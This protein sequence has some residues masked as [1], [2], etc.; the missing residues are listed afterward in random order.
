MQRFRCF[1]LIVVLLGCLNC[2][3]AQTLLPKVA[4]T[5]PIGADTDIW[6]WT[7]DGDHHKPIVKLQNSVSMGTGVIISI[8][9]KNPNNKKTEWV[10]GICLT[11]Y[12]VVY[13]W[14]P[15]LTEEELK[16][17]PE[18][19]YTKDR[20]IA[21]ENNWQLNRYKILDTDRE[22]DLAL[23][24]VWVP[25]CIVPA[26]VGTTPIKAGDSLEITGLGGGSPLAR[27]RHYS[28]AAHRF[29][30]E[31][32][33]HS[34]VV[35]MLGDS[36]GPVFNSKQEVVGIN[37]CIWFTWTPHE[38]RDHHGHM[39]DIGWPLKMAGVKPIN[40]LIEKNK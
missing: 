37:N 3:E 40:D 18:K 33:I 7:P 34:D 24:Q 35:A 15:G 13:E 25:D 23:L 30:D 10:Q 1:V 6:K 17:F 19:P 31:W 27:L 9:D 12:H 36:G 8:D 20:S 29:T 4:E 16:Q 38:I 11:A 22:N 39:A 21:Y 26:K 2:A 14:T 32:V 28:A 5:K